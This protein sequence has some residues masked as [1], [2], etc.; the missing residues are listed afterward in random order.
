MADFGFSRPISLSSDLLLSN[1]QAGAALRQAQ[2]FASRGANNLSRSNA[3]RPDTSVPPPWDPAASPLGQA[4]VLTQALANGE[5]FHED[6]ES[7][8]DTAAPEDQQKLF[9]LYQGIRRL[10]ALGIEATDDTIT[11][12][13]RRL[14]DRRLGEGIT[15]LESFLAVTEFEA[16][17]FLQ[18]AEINRANSTISIERNR[19]DYITGVVH[20]GAFDDVVPGFADDAE[21]TITA[22][23]VTGDVVVNINL[24]DLGTTPRTLDNVADF[25]NTELAAAELFSTFKRVKIGEPDENGVVPG[26]QFGFQI[27]GSS[28][29]PLEFSAA[30]A[31]PAIYTVGTTGSDETT[32]ARLVKYDAEA[33]GG[34]AID[35]STRLEAAE[36]ATTEFLATKVGTNGEIYAIVRSDGA[37]A[38]LAPRGED[39][40]YLVRF[41]STGKPAFTR[42]LGAA[43][44]VDVRGLAIGADGSVVL[45]GKVSGVFSNTTQ[46]GGT[47]S[48]VVKYDGNGTEQFIKRFGANADDQANG[49]VVANDGTIYVVGA[50]NGSLSGPHNGGSDGYIRALDTN[51]D[52][53][54]TRQ[55]GT[56]NAESATAIA[57]DANGDL[58]V[59]S[60]E[61]GIGKLTKYSA[62]NGTDPALWQHDL[63]SLDNGS[64][65]SLS[66]NGSAIIVGGTVGANNGLGAGIVAHSGANDGFVIRVDE[67]GGGVPTRIWTNFLGTAATDR[68]TGIDTANDKLYAA[69]TTAGSLPGGGVLDGTRNAFISRFDLTTGILE[70]TSQLTGR[71]GIATANALAIDPAGTS[72]LDVFGLPH[73]LAVTSDSRVVTERTV[74]REGDQLQISIDGGPRRSVTIDANDTYRALTFKINAILVLDGTSRTVRGSVG[75]TLRIEAADEH[76]IELFA[77]PDGR[78]LLSALGIPEGVIRTNPLLTTGE[79]SSAAPPIYGLGFSSGIGL[80]TLTAAIS[81]NKVLEDAL[82]LVRTAYRQL[83]IDPAL[84]DLLTNGRNRSANGPVPAFLTAQIANYTAGLA[85]LTGGGGGGGFF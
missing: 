58:L 18:G 53:L 33:I 3:V 40:I 36:D 61:N 54:F 2:A 65:A 76:T 80:T 41:D 8:S 14:L 55:F 57:L 26:N 27:V 34:P 62:S 30:V 12:S 56:S 81:A 25:I 9:A 63:G 11:D 69:G 38:G 37:I 73:G 60:S 68:I 1:Y 24:A 21:F 43:G 6:L 52:T 39:D 84:Q 5:F 71:G 10:A 23:R 35:F 47:D 49:V 17:S 82:S 44:D 4:A 28:T 16:L 50:T 85:R 29:E 31:T 42:A 74:A 59:A 64:I 72:V 79:V 7:F 20:Q 45:S 22:K 77:G 51:G 19:A 13:R 48:F 70:G 32:T 75:D 83:T 15:Q 67:D 46:L 78:D 66:V